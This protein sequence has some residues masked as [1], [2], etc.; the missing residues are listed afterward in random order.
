MSVIQISRA[1]P[2]RDI[3]Q[4]LRELAAEIERGDQ[5][6]VSNIAV[7]TICNGGVD[8]PFVFGMPMRR[9]EVIGLLD[10]AKTLVVDDALGDE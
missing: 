9:L 7:V 4:Q 2:A 1:D 8:A 3:P 5:G 6:A 10:I